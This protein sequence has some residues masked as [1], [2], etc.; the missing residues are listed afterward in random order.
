MES[1]ICIPIPEKPLGGMHTFLALFKRWLRDRDIPLTEDIEAEYSTLFVNSWA[2]APELIAS[3]KQRNPSISIV[4]RLDGSAEL[5]G[6]A[7][8]ADRIQQAVSKYANLLI[9]QSEFSRR[10]LK[11]RHIVESD[12]PVIY[13][14][15]DLKL[16]HPEGSRITTNEEP[17]LCV[18]S[19]SPNKMKGTWKVGRIAKANPDIK[20]IL[21]GQFPE[22]PNS[23]TLTT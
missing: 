2:V 16:F 10:V 22:L 23:P 1:R 8:S 21:V 14:P 4:Q 19:H 13:N 11:N 7:A 9:F 20:F 15:V 18:I 5:Y 17:T 12:G 3:A 6:R